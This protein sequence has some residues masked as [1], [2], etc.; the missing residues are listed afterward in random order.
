MLQKSRNG[1]QM[2]V[3]TVARHASRQNAGSPVV[4][5]AALITRVAGLRPPLP[6]LT[7]WRAR[8][9]ARSANPEQGRAANAP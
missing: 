6:T 7:R 1:S 8:P 9:A 3:S 4:C 5:R 2:S